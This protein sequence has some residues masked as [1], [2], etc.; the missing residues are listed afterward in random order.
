MRFNL[1]AKLYIYVNVIENINTTELTS[2]YNKN[3]ALI[4]ELEDLYSKDDKILVGNQNLSTFW[5]IC[6]ASIISPCVLLMLYML[7]RYRVVL[8]NC[9]RDKLFSTRSREGTKPAI[10]ETQNLAPLKPEV[11]VVVVDQITETIYPVLGE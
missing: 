3:L 4:K 10:E 8:I 2:S 7:A 5:V 6:T 1:T 11:G 9:T